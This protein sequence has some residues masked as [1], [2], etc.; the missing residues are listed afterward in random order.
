MKAEESSDDNP[1]ENQRHQNEPEPEAEAIND[2]DNEYQANDD[3][4]STSSSMAIEGFVQ[5]DPEDNT[6]QS[7]SAAFVEQV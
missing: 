4:E 3:N 6:V 5:G 7:Q 2:S 1:A